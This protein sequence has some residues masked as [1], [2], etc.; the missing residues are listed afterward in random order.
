MEQPQ[1]G[2]AFPT[3]FTLRVDK[4][5]KQYEKISVEGGYAKAKNSDITP[6]MD[7]ST[8]AGLDTEKTITYKK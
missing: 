3:T 7:L 8:I 5:W 2:F 4:K 1:L 6:A